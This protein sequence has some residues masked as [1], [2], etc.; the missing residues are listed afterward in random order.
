MNYN[1]EEYKEILSIFKAESEEIIQSLNDGFMELEKDPEDKTPIKKLF[2]SAHSIKGAARM[3]GFNGIQDIA[4]KLEDI[5]TFW[6]KDGIKIDADSFDIIYDVCDFLLDAVSKSVQQQSDY[7]DINFAKV[8]TELDSFI[9]AK[10]IRSI[11]VSDETSSFDINSQ[12]TDI[13]AVLLEL[14]FVLDKGSNEENIEEIIMVISDN[15][16]ILHN[17]FQKSGFEELSNHI[18]LIISQLSSSINN[19]EKLEIINARTDEQDLPVCSGKI[20]NFSM[21]S[22]VTYKI[23][24]KTRDKEYFA[25]EVI[26]YES[27]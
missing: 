13:N 11:E 1:P 6:K 14:L 22:D 19:P 20:A 24:V 8:L 21:S 9:Q 12:I 7:Y 3:L 5:L 17:L 10:N 16:D 27:N 23:Y 26:G 25:V 4:H 15:L 18:S 2:Q